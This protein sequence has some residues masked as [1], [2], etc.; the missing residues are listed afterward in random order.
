MT[1]YKDIL[2]ISL[3]GEA[4]L[5]SRGCL[6]SNNAIVEVKGDD[7]QLISSHPDW[8]ELTYVSIIE[9]FS[10][11]NGYVYLPRIITSKI[12]IL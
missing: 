9:V 7:W 5:Q 2:C 4:T 10:E 6:F 3:F 12:N 8:E 1:G 11:V